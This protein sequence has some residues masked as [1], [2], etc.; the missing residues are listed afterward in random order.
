[1]KRSESVGALMAALSA[2]QKNV[3]AI[4]KNKE[5]PAF[6]SKYADL[7]TIISTVTP[8]LEANALA[9]TQTFGRSEGGDAVL[10]TLLVHHKSG[11]WI[12]DTAT[13]VL[14]KATAQGFGSAGTYARRYALSAMLGIAVDDDDDG[15]AASQPSRPAAPRQ[16]RRSAPSKPA[17]GTPGAVIVETLNAIADPAVRAAAKTAFSEEYGKPDAIPDDQADQAIAYARELAGGTEQ[18]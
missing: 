15:N 3:P 2:F 9:F 6:R 13:L 12:E 14:E 16:Q 17:A 18:Q 1:M 10:T 5:N 4:A 7:S 8:V 11:E